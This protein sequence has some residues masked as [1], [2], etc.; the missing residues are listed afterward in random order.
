[1]FGYHLQLAW[2][3]LRRSPGL[4]AL[5]VL[6]LAL[7]IGACMTTMAIYHV[8]S[9]DP[10]PA[11]SDRLFNVQL[12]ALSTPRKPGND[13]VLLQLTLVDAEN[14][15][16][17]AK[18]KRQV[19]MSGGGVLGQAEGDTRKPDSYRSRYTSADFFP[20]FDVPFL[21]GS[22]WSATE[23]QVEAAVT[24]LSYDTA[25]K[26]FGKTDVVGQTFWLRHV[27]SRIVDGVAKETVDV[28][29]R[30]VGV[31]KPWRPAIQFYD[32]SAPTS[33]PADLYL[34][35]TL[36]MTYKL[37]PQGTM[38]CWGPRPDG[39][40]LDRRAHCDWVQYWV[41]LERAADASGFTNY[42]L[43][44]AA[45]QKKAG[46]FANRP[47]AD[48]SSV[49]KWLADNQAVPRDVSLQFVLALVFL[50]V[51]VVNVVGLQLTK[52]LRRSSEVGVR[53][54]LGA[55][56]E[57]VFQQFCIEALVLGLV[58]CVAGLCFT[59]L[60]LW[61]VR[62]SKSAYADVVALDM[63]LLGMSLVVSLVAALVAGVLPAWRA[64]HINPAQ[65]IKA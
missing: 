30:V 20:M 8:L 2:R 3:S 19:M 42:L 61:A 45:E 56:R 32:L 13:A 40:S 25:Q 31:L 7:G 15:L 60:G 38:N 57:Q 12:D 37:P 11:K 34:P 36:A 18:A 22:A 33:A 1:M 54:A 49:M 65:Q 6:T 52:C 27:P 50:L 28:P 26:T 47:R 48:L 62:A 16:H 4:T 53:R 24:V 51:C 29:L 23:D 41:E 44:Y 14:L 63:P 9:A 46:R 43:Q 55:T 59:G 10:I 21:H 35:F 64:A 17:D 39:D 5:I 58:G